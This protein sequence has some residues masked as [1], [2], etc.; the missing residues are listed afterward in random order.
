MSVIIYSSISR[1]YLLFKFASFKQISSS[2]ILYL[3]KRK[4][5]KAGEKTEKSNN[6]CENRVKN[7]IQI[8]IFSLPKIFLAILKRNGIRN[9]RYFD[10]CLADKLIQDNDKQIY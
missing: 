8:F 6:A 7:I 4:N 3:F 5:N 10:L 1:L 2:L 9:L